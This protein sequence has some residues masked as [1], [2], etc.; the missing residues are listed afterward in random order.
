MKS[1]GQIYQK[2]KQARFRHIK[3][4]VEALLKKTSRNCS[5]FSPLPELPNPLGICKLD[6]RVCGKERSANCEDFAHL[7]GREA[8]K[9]SLQEFFSKRD[10]ADIAV[11]FPDVAALLWVLEGETFEDDPHEGDDEDYVS[12]SVLVGT[13]YGLQ[14]WV[15]T[16][17]DSQVF[18]AWVESLTGK[19]RDLEQRVADLEGECTHLEGQKRNLVEESVKNIEALN[20]YRSVAETSEKIILELRAQLDGLSEK[21][22]LLASF[23][24]TPELPAKRTSFWGRLFK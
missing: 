4:E 1:A 10:I 13:F 16:E 11:R 9:G 17:R 21:I 12:G 19:V 7:H 18:V 20:A 15:N 2:L 23:E 8:I 5:H 14:V 24:P 6:Y 22:L 3:K